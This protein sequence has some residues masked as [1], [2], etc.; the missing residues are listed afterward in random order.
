MIARIKGQVI[1]EKENAVVID[2]SGIFYEVLVPASV[3][4]RISEAVDP[5]GIVTLITFHYL[6]VGPSSATPILIGFLSE[7]EREF[8]QQFI[9]VSGI[10]P[11]AAVRA[12]DRS[13]AEIAAAIDR[14]DIKFLK[15]LPGIGQQK[16]KEI[17][18]KLQG[19]AGRFGLIRD[20]QVKKPVGPA[21]AFQAETLAVLTQ[22]QYKKAEAEAMILKALERD[23]SITTTEKLLNEI[24][25][26]RTAS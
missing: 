26:Q 25:K 12:I 8:F 16:A 9:S 24:Y 15:S 3:L 23:P 19:K 6:Q 4:Q 20:E 1:E 18:A 11:K 10:G 5:Q 13:I 17:V 14:G 2:V 7:I 21:P 22:L